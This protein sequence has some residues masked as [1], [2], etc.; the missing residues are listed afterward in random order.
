[1]SSKLSTWEFMQYGPSTL[2]SATYGGGRQLH[3]NVISGP[4]LAIDCLPE[5]GVYILYRNRGIQVASACDMRKCSTTQICRCAEQQYGLYENAN[6]TMEPRAEGS[7]T[8]DVLSGSLKARVQSWLHLHKA[9]KAVRAHGLCFLAH[10][11]TLSW[12]AAFDNLTFRFDYELQEIKDSTCPADDLSSCAKGV[13]E[14]PRRVIELMCDA[15]RDFVDGGDYAIQPASTSPR[16]E[17]CTEDNH[18]RTDNRG[19]VSEWDDTDVPVRAHASTTQRNHQKGTPKRNEEFDF[20]L[21]EDLIEEEFPR[22]GTTLQRMRAAKTTRRGSTSNTT[23][24]SADDEEAPVPVITP[25]K[26]MRVGRGVVRYDNSYKRLGLH[27]AHA[28]RW[29]AVSC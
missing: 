23:N 21:I 11:R 12:D 1:M 29:V 26:N 7:S 5:E 22:L 6:N 14:C 18:T 8:E 4:K 27:R 2:V 24:P 28:D 20:D 13:K 9:A 17:K 3:Q 25:P 16:D 19:D 10:P 15:W